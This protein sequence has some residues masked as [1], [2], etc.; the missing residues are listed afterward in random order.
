MKVLNCAKQRNFKF[1]L[2]FKILSL[3]PGKMLFH[4]S[5]TSKFSKIEMHNL[6]TQPYPEIL[7]DIKSL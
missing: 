4:N 3:M 1:L 7:C 5:I 6:N 2:E